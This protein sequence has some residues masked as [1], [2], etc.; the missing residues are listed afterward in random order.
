MARKKR[1]IFD[2]NYLKKARDKNKNTWLIIGASTLGVI[3][4]IILVVLAT[5]G[6]ERRVVESKKPAFTFKDV[7][8]VEAGS[9]VPNASDYFTKLENI[10]VKDIKIT[11]PE[12]FEKSYDLSACSDSVLGIISENEDILNEDNV[13]EE[14]DCIKVTLQT[15]A[16]YGM[17]VNVLGKDYTIN[18]RVVDTEPPQVVVNN[19]EIFEGDTYEL[20]DFISSCDDAS[21]SCEYNYITEDV[22]D[23]GEPIDYS[24][25]TAAGDYV[26]KFMAK[27]I[28]GNSQICEAKLSIVKSER[29]L[30]LV[31]FNSNGGTEVKSVRVQD[32][33]LISEPEAP[34]RNGYKFAGWYRGNNKFDFSQPITTNVTLTAHWENVSTGQG[35]TEV[36]SVSLN[37]KTMYLNIGQSKTVTATVKPSSALNKTVTWSSS[38][39]SIA[40]VNNGVITGIKEGTVKITAT[41]S[42][43]SAS[44]EIIVRNGGT[45]TCQYGD[46]NYNTNYYTLSVNLTK[47]G[48]AINPNSNPEES[49]SNLDY[50]RVRNDLEAMG[51][52]FSTDDI[53]W[54]VSRIPV[55]N[56][57]GLGLVGYQ[58][59]INLE[60]LDQQNPYYVMKAEYVLRADGSR[61]IRESNIAKN[62]IKFQ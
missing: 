18:L 35:G 22:N 23:E 28:Y 30:Y 9:E 48:C 41:A 61:I 55:K 7:V 49:L 43:K 42:G 2:E 45:G 19:Y 12:E 25:F 38:D 20:E 31:T 44:V 8:V 16:E 37:Y 15:P 11:E 52:K 29:L 62:G 33:S 10:D 6:H 1:F 54:R 27:D 36:S 47:N 24:A 57:S 50:T 13:T 32:G 26:I 3:L 51:I 58:I 34:T 17:T 4:V 21:Y 46:A 39:N 40:T 5:K 53:V 59:V 56:T 60:V 14:F